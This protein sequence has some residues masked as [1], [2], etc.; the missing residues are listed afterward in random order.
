M[1]SVAPSARH[2]LKRF[3]ELRAIGALA[4]L[5]FGKL[6]NYPPLAAVEVVSNRFLLRLQA[7]PRS[8]LALCRDAIIGDKVSGMLRAHDVLFAVLRSNV[9]QN[10]RELNA[11]R[12]SIIR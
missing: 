3:G 1:I 10:R 6:A 7:K 2:T 9:A 11:D 5:H 4:A 8:A 12:D